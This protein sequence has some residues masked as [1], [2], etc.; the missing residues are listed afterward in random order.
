MMQP[1][2]SRAQDTDEMTKKRR[3]RGKTILWSLAGLVL[4]VST[5]IV[6]TGLVAFGRIT[7]TNSNDVASFF[8][9]GLISP[10]ELKQEGDGRITIAL[11][12]IGGENH[13]GGQLADTIQVLSLDPINKTMSMISV[14]RDLYVST[15]SG[16][17][18]I[19]SVYA[20]AIDTCNKSKKCDKNGDPGGQAMKEIL[21]TIL[22]IPIQYF[23]RIDFAG[24]EKMIDSIGGI[25]V[26]VDRPLNDPRYPDASVQGY[27]PLYIP[28]GLQTFNGSKALKYARSREST[29]DFDRSRR[30]QQILAAT[31]E[32]ALSLNVLANPKKVTDLVSILG[33]HL[34]TDLSLEE[35]KDLVGLLKEID[36]TKTATTVLD[37][38]ADSPLKSINDPIAGYI[39][40]PKKGLS[41]YSE[42]QELIDG[43]IAEPY[44]VKEAAKVLIVNAGAKATAVE[45]QVK[46][47][48][49]LGYIVVGSQTGPK[50]Q[51]ASTLTVYTAKPYTESLLKKRFRITGAGT[52]AASPP[53]GAD[54]VLTF[55]SALQ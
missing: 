37:T 23:V 31:R 8:R 36:G 53:N 9:K 19:N 28:A 24:F 10:D 48:K 1:I 7:V 55:G 41:D 25:Q 29:S 54:L 45:A 14:P 17:S 21:T 27:S 42:V 6:T 47:L 12:G 4:A 35:I 44:I 22:D 5:W 13:P 38:S 20:T 2:L 50:A 18:K 39:I 49:S 3:R 33:R 51:T 34:R 26:Y 32:K 11:L 15:A 30:Q 52:K 46:K 40:V 43:A 16:R